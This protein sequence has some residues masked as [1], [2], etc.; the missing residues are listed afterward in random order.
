MWYQTAR[1]MVRDAGIPYAALM[2]ALG[3]T[4]PAAVGHYLAGRRQPTP[5]QLKALADALGVRIDDFF[6][7]APAGE[8]PVPTAENPDPEPLT[9][10]QRLRRRYAWSNPDDIEETALIRKVLSAGR[11]DDI[12]TLCTGVGLARVEAAAAMDRTLAGH[13]RLARLLANIRAG[14][15]RACP[16]AA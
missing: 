15:D 6:T 7:M 9:P 1:K 11:F 2:P 4:T 3:V 5:D 13:S 14:H 10:M 12:L 8:H 16:H